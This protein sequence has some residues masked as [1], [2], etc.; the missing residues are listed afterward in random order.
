M[1]EIEKMYENAGIKKWLYCNI[2]N[3]QEYGLGLCAETNCEPFYPPFTAKKQLNII[4]FLG[5]IRDFHTCGR[6]CSALD[7]EGDSVE[8]LQDKF[9][10]SL[11]GVINKLWTDMSQEEKQ[12][13]KE[14]LK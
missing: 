10:E 6:Y 3:A 12:Q 11:A 8:S 7:S 4:K 9:E 5:K 2:C 14:I 1:S 13:I